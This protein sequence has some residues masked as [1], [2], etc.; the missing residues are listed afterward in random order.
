MK[1][2]KKIAFYLILIIAAQSSNSMH[3]IPDKMSDEEKMLKLALGS[4]GSFVGYFHGVGALKIIGGWAAKAYAG[5]TAVGSAIIAAPATPYVA[6]GAGA[7]YL[8]YKVYRHMNPTPQQIAV[9]AEHRASAETSNNIAAQAKAERELAEC[10]SDNMTSP[11]SPSGVPTPCT[12]AACKLGI[13]A[14]SKRLDD[15]VNTFSRH[16]PSVAPSQQNPSK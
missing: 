4:T 13:R 8:G 14:G 7:T 2:T 15:I 1:Y 11:R 6:A 16:A 10:L 5:T 12:R 9:E 3:G